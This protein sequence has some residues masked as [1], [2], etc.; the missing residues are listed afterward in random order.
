MRCGDQ[1]R[2]WIG[3]WVLSRVGGRFLQL[4]STRDRNQ[5]TFSV[6]VRDWFGHQLSQ[7]GYDFVGATERIYFPTDCET[8]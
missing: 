7:I 3:H 4:Q 6:K 8:D 2:Q 5:T 1:R